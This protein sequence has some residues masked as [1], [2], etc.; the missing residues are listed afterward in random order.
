MLG[1]QSR[2]A[3]SV[4]EKQ[5]PEVVTPKAG[6]TTETGAAAK[7]YMSR[8]EDIS[9]RRPFREFST[10]EVMRMTRGED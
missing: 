5:P 8:L 3:K 2:L 7:S 6:V 4:E 1:R 10:E 9:R